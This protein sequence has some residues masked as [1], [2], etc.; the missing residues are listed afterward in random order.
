MS[1]GKTGKKT[2]K[3]ISQ[4]FDPFDATSTVT[5]SKYMVVF[6]IR[7]SCRFLYGTTISTSQFNDWV[8]VT[9]ESRG[10]HMH[11]IALASWGFMTIGKS[12]S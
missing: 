10:S 1:S 7:I 5:Y 6:W 12:R 2:D 3:Q 4:D 9:H 8:T 11:I